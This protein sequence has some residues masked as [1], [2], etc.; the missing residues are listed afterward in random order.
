MLK[1]QDQKIIKNDVILIGLLS[2]LSILVVVTLSNS[3]YAQEYE[4]TNQWGSKGIA[5]G[6]C[7][8]PAGIAIDSNDNVYVGD[9]AGRSNIIQKFSN[10]GTFLSGFGILG[11]GP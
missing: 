10:N 11:H 6:Q 9:F 7:I 8:Q 3:T 2:I 5:N 4:F 1:T